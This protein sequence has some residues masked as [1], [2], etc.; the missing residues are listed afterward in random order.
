VIAVVSHVPLLALFSLRNER[1]LFGAVPRPFS[2][3]GFGTF[4]RSGVLHESA[5]RGEASKC[6]YQF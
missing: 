4:A 6:E 5:V 2:K 1:T 3:T